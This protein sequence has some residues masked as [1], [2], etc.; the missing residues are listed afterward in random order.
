MI[1][2]DRGSSRLQVWRGGL[3]GEADQEVFI[4]FRQLEQELEFGEA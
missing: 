2:D 1:E 3:E 4:E